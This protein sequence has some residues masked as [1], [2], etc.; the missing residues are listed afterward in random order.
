MGEGRFVWDQAEEAWLAYRDNYA[1]SHP[2]ADQR[3]IGRQM[4]KREFV[5]GF[6]AGLEAA[7]EVQR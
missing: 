6:I 1:R 3:R 2:W 5:A 7:N 4:R